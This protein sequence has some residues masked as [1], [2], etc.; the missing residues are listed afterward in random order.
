MIFALMLSALAGV[1]HAQD[2]I[3]IQF[4]DDFLQTVTCI[5]YN[6]NFSNN[7]QDITAARHL[8]EILEKAR[9]GVIIYAF[10][11]TIINYYEL[12]TIL[13]SN[14]ESTLLFWPAYNDLYVYARFAINTI[15]LLLL[16]SITNYLHRLCANPAGILSNQNPYL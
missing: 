2:S 10:Y 15:K 13:K 14:R 1:S 6:L 3:Y 4:S 12:Q 8:T 16:I 9:V 7:H 5:N 11:K